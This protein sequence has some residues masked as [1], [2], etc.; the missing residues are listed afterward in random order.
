MFFY[1]IVFFYLYCFICKRFGL[2][3]IV[4]LILVRF[5]VFIYKEVI[6]LFGSRCC[7]LYIVNDD[8]IIGLLNNLKI[9]DILCLNRCI[10]VDLIIRIWSYVI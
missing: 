4:V 9:I 3:F 7:F 1:R 5:L 10:I 6:I 8:F 2:K